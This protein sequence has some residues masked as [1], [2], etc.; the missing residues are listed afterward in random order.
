VAKNWVTALTRWT[1]AG[2]VD[3][4]TAA[5]IRAFELE[6]EGS[7]GLRWPIVLALAFGALMLGA[8]V[9]LFVSAN[10]AMLSPGVRFALV[11][12]LVAVFHAA[13][14]LTTERFPAM[15]TT[16]HAVGTVA[17]GAGIFLGG[18]IFNL[19]EHWPGGLMLW[20]LGALLAWALLRDG[21]QMAYVAILAP[22]WLA[23]EWL[24][25]AT[26]GNSGVDSRVALIVAC[27]AF[28]LA[29][30][31]F[32]AVHTERADHRL[33]ILLWLGGVAL[34]P[35][36]IVLT[37]VSNPQVLPSTPPPLPIGM[38]ALGW[39]GAFG[40]P[41][42]LSVAVRRA[43]A[44]PNLLAACWVVALVNLRP[45]AGEVFPYVWWALSA[46]GLVAWGLREAR[47]ERINMGAA[48]FAGTVGVFY[49]SEVMDKLGRSASLIG[50]GLLFLLG[51]WALER[52]RRH[53][54]LRAR[55][56]AA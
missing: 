6:R 31:Y 32:T 28:L 51:G 42:L 5:R 17:L 13:G 54:V 3:Q 14:A 38:R 30:T 27:G 52:L 16:L 49:F 8:G 43:A 45:L 37:V 15:A 36:A 34:L 12:L 50:F 24:V 48:M 55:G 7:A 18:Q 41:L 20:T 26:A 19:E 47:G 22:A 40:L 10:W 56:G 33:R 9:L 39:I 2:L 25:A 53:L 11:I 1:D 4:D 44:W 21:P 23:S 46:T 35:T 29:L